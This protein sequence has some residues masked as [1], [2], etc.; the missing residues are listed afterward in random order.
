MVKLSHLSRGATTVITVF[1]LLFCS[2]PFNAFGDSLS[3]AEMDYAS[4]VALKEEIDQELRSRP[5]SEPIILHPGQYLVGSY[6][7]EGKY[8][9]I[10]DR[11]EGLFDSAKIVLYADKSKYD[12]REGFSYGDYLMSEYYSIGEQSKTIDLKDGNYLYIQNAPVKISLID[13]SE[14]EYYSYTPP[15]GTTVP[16][17]IYTIGS[18]IPAGFYTVYPP[19]YEDSTHIQI[20]G[21]R[22][23]YESD[24]GKYIWIVVKATSSASESSFKLDD[25]NILI[26][27]GAVIMKKS[28]P[29]SF[30]Q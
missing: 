22:E 15:T 21:S 23:A 20:F 11:P 8:Y 10:I 30:D 6:I 7:K 27:D 1:I 17:G 9:V 2:I 5:E 28:P 19:S 12:E 24:D 3:I 16:I 26:V 25:G 13:Y 14:D 29:L 4:L 18:E